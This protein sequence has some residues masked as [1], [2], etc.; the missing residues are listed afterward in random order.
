MKPI[1]L[2]GRVLVTLLAVAAALFAVRWLWHY[3]QVEP[4]TRDGR[5]RAD[6]IQIAP[7]VSGLV[8]DIAVSDHQTVRRG[9]RLFVIDQ[10]RFRLALE[11]AA[12]GLLV[13]TT[14]LDQAKRE[15]VR[16]RALGDLVP[17]EVVEQNAS[18]IAELEAARAEAA[19]AC[20]LARLNLAR[21]TV[22]A[23]VDGVVANAA[24]HLGEYVTAGRAVIGLVDS[25]SIR[26]DG[27]FEETKLAQIRVGDRA[28]VQLM[29]ETRRTPGVVESIAPGVEDREKGATGDL[30]P[31]VNPTFSW[32]RLAQRIPVRIKL[33]PKYL[34]H[35]LVVGLTA[36]VVIHPRAEPELADEDLP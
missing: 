22:T 26:V 7:D 11:N 21:T 23:E 28:S 5:V 1:L 9:Q 20:D 6:I 31:N 32:V 24:V 16:N 35:E 17:A 13:Q 12:A 18:K 36:T 19:A 27:Y 4:W 34:D 14:A 15:D 3:Y 8:T 33:D 2:S 30:L 25:H 29:G 10:Q